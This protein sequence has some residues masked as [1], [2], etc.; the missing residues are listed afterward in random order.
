MDIPNK[1]DELLKLVGK[2]TERTLKP[3]AYTP[4]D[5]MRVEEIRHRVAIRVNEVLLQEVGLA[6]PDGLEGLQT[7]EGIEGVIRG[8]AAAL[9]AVVGTFIAGTRYGGADGL[10]KCASDAMDWIT[11]PVTKS[12]VLGVSLAAKNTSLGGDE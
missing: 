10:L 7:S 11:E 2:T 8:G 3:K 1:V 4:E 5:L 6:Y 9:A 12:I